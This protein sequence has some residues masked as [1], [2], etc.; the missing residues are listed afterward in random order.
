MKTL[1]AAMVLLFV[2]NI[3][4]ALAVTPPPVET[5]ETPTVDMT[6]ANLR[7]L[8]FSARIVGNLQI[9]GTHDAT[10]F[11]YV[12][13]EKKSEALLFM[14]WAPALVKGIPNARVA[15]RLQPELVALL[16]ST[17]ANDYAAS[18]RLEKIYAAAFVLIKTID[19][20][21]AYNCK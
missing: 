21:W 8:S 5:T 16:E 2:A 12:W 3:G 9:E 13:A 20:A 17:K 4:S 11:S 15:E 7:A 10:V 19:E 1:L 6:C 18:K 14:Q